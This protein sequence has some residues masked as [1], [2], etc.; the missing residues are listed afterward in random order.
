MSTILCSLLS[1]NMS[2]MATCFT[3]FLHV[4]LH[5]HHKGHWA[6][7]FRYIHVVCFKI[8]TE[9]NIVQRKIAKNHILRNMYK[10]GQSIASYTNL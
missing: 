10:S 2:E 3:P 6:R 8:W 5:F 7:A 1:Q 4:L 9:M